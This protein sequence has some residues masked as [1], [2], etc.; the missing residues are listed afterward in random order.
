MTGHS[1]RSV[2][3]AVS[4]RVAQAL[5]TRTFTAHWRTRYAP[6]PTGY[7][8][9]GHVVNAIHVWG[10][11]RAFGGQV[12]LRIEDHD[13]TRCRLEFERALLDDLDWL[14][15]SPDIGATDEFRDGHSFRRQSDNRARYAA[16]LQNLTARELEY[17]C[18]CTRKDIAEITGDRF[19]V[20]SPYPGTCA[21]ANHGLAAARRFRVSAAA[22]SFDDLC[23]GPQLQ[24]PH[25]QCGDFLIRDR[26][27]NFSYQFCVTVD[28]WEQQIDVIIRGEDLLSSTGRQLQLAR[29]LGR[30][31]PPQFLHHSLLRRPD[32]LK[33]S[34]SLG[35]TGVR[36]MRDAGLSRELVLGRAAFAC[37][38]LDRDGALEQDAIPSLFS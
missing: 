34:K 17:G 18:V 14:G 15:F 32:G 16:A 9:L 7:L 23:L 11:A 20:E 36:E 37:G 38:L 6:A 4:L 35:D 8:H 13:G 26:N 3:S 5:A 29:V 10:V 22:E 2:R 28:D 19:G 24:T 31:A 30:N 27:E 33:L 25:R 12:L 1:A 21:Q